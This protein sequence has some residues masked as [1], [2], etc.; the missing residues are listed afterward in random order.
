MSQQTDRSEDSNSRELVAQVNMVD[1]E[2]PDDAGDWLVPEPGVAAFAPT[3]EEAPGARAP[4]LPALALG[5]V[6]LAVIGASMYVI[7]RGVF[8]MIPD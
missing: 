5:L 1:E 4:I 2:E 7:L 3:A 6:A 8:E